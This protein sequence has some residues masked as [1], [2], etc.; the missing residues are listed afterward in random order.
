MH[1]F[2]SSWFFPDFQFLHV[3]DLS[4]FKNPN[5]LFIHNNNQF[6][7]YTIIYTKFNIKNRSQNEADLKKEFNF[8]EK[9]S[10][11]KNRN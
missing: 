2:R 11:E 8:K 4:N 1:L 6:T 3:I 9:K 10:E 7:N 5:K